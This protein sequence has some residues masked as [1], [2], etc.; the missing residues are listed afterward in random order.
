RDGAEVLSDE[1]AELEE[2]GGIRAGDAADAARCARGLDAAA[3]A[4]RTDEAAG[5]ALIAADPDVGGGERQVRR[6][7]DDGA[8]VE[9]DEPTGAHERAGDGRGGVGIA[10]RAVVRPDEAADAG[11]L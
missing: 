8:L 9:A 1:T 11:G 4:V 10:H 2:V 7:A 5:G 6:R 3:G